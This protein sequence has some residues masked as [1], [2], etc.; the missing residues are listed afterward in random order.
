LLTIGEGLASDVA[1]DR[2]G[3]LYVAT[4]GRVVRI[5][6]DGKTTPVAGTGIPGSNPPADGQSALNATLGPLSV[7]ADPAGNLY[8]ADQITRS[9]WVVNSSGMTISKYADLN[10]TRL[11]TDAAG[12][13]YAIGVDNRVYKVQPGRASAIDGLT[14]VVAL[15]SGP[16]NTLLVARQELDEDPLHADSEIRA[17]TVSDWRPTRRLIQQTLGAR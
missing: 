8:L 17:V 3:N 4:S 6:P 16:D 1:L 2:Q 5:S 14:N 12:N 15:A 13:L 11:V 9:I 7:A 10:A